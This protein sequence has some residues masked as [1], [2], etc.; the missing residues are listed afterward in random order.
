[1]FLNRSYSHMGVL[2]K[3]SITI[4]IIEDIAI[5]KAQIF[6]SNGNI[7]GTSDKTSDIHLVVWK[8]LADITDRFDDII[9]KRFTS[10]ESGYEE[11]LTWGDQHLNKKSFT[12]T[13]DDISERAKIQ[14]E[15]Y[16]KI[17]GTRQLVAVDYINFIDVNDLQGSPTPPNN[18]KHGDLWLDTSVI[19]PRLMMWDANL[20]MWVEVTVAGSD[21][22]NLL[23]NSNFYKA[24]FDYW[25]A[26][27]NPV[28]E[29]ESLNS[30]KWARIKS[31]TSKADICGIRQVVGNAIAKSNYTFQMLSQ[32]YIQSES[33]EGNALVT[34]YSIDENNVR[35]LI[36]E[37]VFDITNDAHIYSSTFVTLE[38]T[39][40]IEVNI[41][42]NKGASFDY[43]V[44]QTKLSNYLVAT[45]WELAIED[46]QDAL[47]NKVGNTHEEV[48]NSLT[49]D[50]KMQG[51]Y[52]DID[53]HGRRNFY[54]NATYIKSGK[55][56]GEYIE[57]KNLL[58]TK[59]DGNTTL[60]IDS[61][62]DVFLKAKKLQV[63]HTDSS[64]P[65]DEGEFED[66]AGVSDIAWKVEIKSSNGIV[67]KN[68]IVNTILEAVIY[69]GKDDVTAEIDVSRI[70]WKRTST[71]PE[72]DDKWNNS[73]GM[74]T[75]TINITQSDV[76]QRATFTCEI[77]NEK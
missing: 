57:A 1:M 7:F 30:K 39:K 11:D 44:T 9:W 28:L 2:T 48:F 50:G 33:P 19:P 58:V 36:K 76:Y 47:D 32:V 49:D 77:E 42:G 18:P 10:K 65:E 27:N 71:D 37:E 24:T 46:I 66:V 25:T 45:E 56:L 72:A 17:N 23:R 67:F 5:Y 63:L 41:S 12:L 6:S 35:T 59:N 73:K 75:R 40:K 69:R 38:N 26:I 55:L 29:I 21:R 70:N 15:V 3:A 16:A 8:G 64:M 52:V 61:A 34:F 14:V 68:G 20:G 54:F 62:G 4:Q 31:N 74:G 51:M 60:K 53:E 22:R 13:R 43:L